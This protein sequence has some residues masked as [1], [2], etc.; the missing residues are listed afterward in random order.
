MI[1]LS[2]KFPRINQIRNQKKNHN[3][4]SKHIDPVPRS[5]PCHKNRRRPIRSNIFPV[6][7]IYFFQNI[8]KFFLYTISFFYFPWIPYISNNRNKRLLSVKHIHI[9]QP[10]AVII[11]RFIF[12]INFYRWNYLYFKASV[13]IPLVT[14]RRN[15]SWISS[16]GMYTDLRSAS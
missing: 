14:T 13:Y 2:P 6:F 8:L 5:F 10:P 3:H 15:S 9:S 1:F 7:F 11:Y 16:F 4:H 12:I